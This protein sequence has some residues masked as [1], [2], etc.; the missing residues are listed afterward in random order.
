[1]HVV[2]T[3]LLTLFIILV[4]MLTIGR[5]MIATFSS[6]TEAWGVAQA[7]AEGIAETRLSAPGGL[8]VN[9]GTTIDVTL[10]NQGNVALAHFAN[11]DVIF[12]IQEGSDVTLAYLTYTTDANPAQGEWAVQG[13]YLDADT[14][15]DEIVDPG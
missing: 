5:E 6:I 3:Y 15:T 1:M 8:T 14:L 9:P 10:I 7:R 2:I 11:W 4:S 13:I 12:E